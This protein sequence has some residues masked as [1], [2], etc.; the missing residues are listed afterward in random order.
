[1]HTLASIYSSWYLCAACA[2]GCLS[3]LNSVG[4]LQ[5]LALRYIL[6]QTI[7][8]F[9][10]CSVVMGTSVPIGRFPSFLFW[11][12]FQILELPSSLLSFVMRAINLTILTPRH[13]PKIFAFLLLCSSLAQLLL[14]VTFCCVP[15]LFFSFVQCSI[16]S[17]EMPLTGFEISLCIYWLTRVQLTTWV[18]KL[19]PLVL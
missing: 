5:Q 16:N 10:Y 9:L 4:F 17:L 1:M 15:F 2:Y 12:H 13:A 7:F 6:S 8:Y 18:H 11:W 14:L 19:Q 3:T